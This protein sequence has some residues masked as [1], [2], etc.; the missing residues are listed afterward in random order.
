[1][2]LT[3]RNRSM[4]TT[5]MTRG[6]RAR[7]M[8]P[9]VLRLFRGDQLAP[10]EGLFLSPCTAPLTWFLSEPVDL[11]YV[12]E[13]WRAVAVAAEV[14]PWRF[15]GL[16]W[17]TRSIVVL[18]AGTLAASHTHAGDQIV[19]QENQETNSRAAGLHK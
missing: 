12:S 6:R 13:D 10:G 5:L 4:S 3:V 8:F 18:P 11:L 7:A 19:V 2:A 1:M 14:P 9:C 16:V 15:A 17:G